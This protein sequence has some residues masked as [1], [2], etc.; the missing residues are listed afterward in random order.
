MEQFIDGGRSMTP[1]GSAR[2]EDGEGRD[3]SSFSTPVF[4]SP[5]GQA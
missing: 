3:S 1:S 2:G 5:E 4:P